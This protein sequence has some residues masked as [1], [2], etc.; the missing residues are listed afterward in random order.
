M[1]DWLFPPSCPCDPQTKAWV[2]RRL[3]WLAEQFPESAFSGHPIVLP[4]PEFFPGTYR[5][6]DTSVRRL[7]AQV[8]EYMVV[9]PDLVQLKFEDQPFLGLTNSAG[10]AIGE[11]AGTYQSGSLRHIIKIYR[12]GFHDSMGLV[13]T[14]AHE[15]AHARLIGE[16]RIDP[17]V[18][19]HELTTDL[20]VVHFGLG[21]FLANTPRVYSSRYSRWPGSKLKM[22][23]YMT[24]PMYGWAMALLALFRGEDHPPWRKYLRSGAKAN[25]DQGV[26]FLKHWGHSDYMPGQDLED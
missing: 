9:E 17:D 8:C 25:L 21:I 4:T 20:T 11:P 13:G 15:L 12:S 18:Y 19:D 16:G 5:G 23:E 3:A 2:E 10:Q 6:D 7:F 26:R 22:P 14:M 1:F 24:D